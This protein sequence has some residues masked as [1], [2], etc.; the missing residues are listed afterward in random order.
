M[1]RYNLP[2]AAPKKRMGLKITIAVMGVVLLIC[3]PNLAADL[4]KLNLDDVSTLGLKL[5]STIQGNSDWRTIQTLFI[6]QKGQRP[7]KVTLN[8]IINGAG[9]VWIDNIVLS[10]EPLAF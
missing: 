8:L 1:L 2:C 4:K 9:T 6:L 7:D 10:K 3:T 5:D